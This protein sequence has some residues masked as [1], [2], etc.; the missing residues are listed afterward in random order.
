MENTPLN[1]SNVPKSLAPL[2]P[3]AEK[4]GISDDVER[5]DAVS[6]ATKSRKSRSGR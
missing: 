5:E 3:L 2:L 6:G 4:W 1:P